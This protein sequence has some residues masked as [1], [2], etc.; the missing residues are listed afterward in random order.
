M[1]VYKGDWRCSRLVLL[2]RLCRSRLVVKVGYFGFHSVMKVGEFCLGCYSLFENWLC[3]VVG[4]RT[5]FVAAWFSDRVMFG[6]FCR[7]E[8]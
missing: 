1:V 4:F 2:G 3:V 8:F 6:V 5:Q 7:T